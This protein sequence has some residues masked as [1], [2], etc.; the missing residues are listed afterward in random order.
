MSGIRLAILYGI[1]PYQLGFCGP[2]NKKDILSGYLRG[3]KINRKQLRD[4][5]KEFEGAYPYYELIAK[6]NNIKN[7]FDE[8]IVRAYWVGN[9]LLEKIKKNA[10]HSF[11]VLI[12]GST[13][14]RIEL[15]GK[16]LDLCRI[17]WGKVIKIGKKITV[18]HQPLIGKN[19]L[20]LGKPIRKE[21]DWD[22][23]L[24]PTVKTG[25]WI[26]FHW[27][28]AVEILTKEDIKNL[29]KYTKI[30]IGIYNKNHE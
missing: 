7:P 16:L 20:K 3:K 23:N 17:G 24:I 8:N 11:H 1:K 9:K 27:N 25:D 12:V 21:V 30:S 15:K 5:L 22:K 26:S 19:K 10:H 29:E 2:E 6:A 18:N 13:T 28:Q 4:L 14:G